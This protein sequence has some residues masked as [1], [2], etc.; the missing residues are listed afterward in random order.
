MDKNP[1]QGEDVEQL[2]LDEAERRLAAF[3]R[4]GTLIQAEVVLRLF[5]PMAA[6]ALLIEDGLDI[7]VKIHRATGRRRKGRYV[8]GALADS[9]RA[10][11][12]KGRN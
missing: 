5:G 10:P 7:P 8:G 6:L 9:A 3:Q 1:A 11:E 12:H 2:W 4:G